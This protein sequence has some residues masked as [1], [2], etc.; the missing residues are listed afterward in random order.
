[1]NSVGYSVCLCKLLMLKQSIN[2]ILLSNNHSCI[3][4]LHN[5][6]ESIDLGEECD[7]N[8]YQVQQA[9]IDA[10]FMSFL[11]QEIR[12]RYIVGQE[13]VFLIFSFGG[14]TVPENQEVITKTYQLSLSTVIFNIINSYRGL[15][16]LEQMRPIKG[17]LKTIYKNEDIIIVMKPHSLLVHPWGHSLA[18]TLM[19]WLVHEYPELSLLPRAGIVHRL[20]RDTTGLLIIARNLA[21]QIDLIWKISNHRFI[22]EYMAICEGVILNDRGTISCK[23]DTPRYKPK[24]QLV[25][26]THF[27]V[28][29]RF[30]CCTYLRLNLETG[31]RHQI[32][33]HLSR[34]LN[35]PLI[36]DRLYNTRFVQRR[37][38]LSN[39]KEYLNQFHRP[40]LHASRI[41]IELLRS[42][43]LLIIKVNMPEDMDYLLDE[44]ASEEQ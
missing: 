10:C 22:R 18:P 42:N 1:M 30:D 36:G 3:T 35:C 9:S 5:L 19:N 34:H 14:S 40:A 26:I 6:L 12:N 17:D 41:V 4:A 16:T 24:D 44:I 13:R 20:D 38:K 27:S 15:F 31:R 25:G 8:I 32:R 33:T 21:S 23:V 28:I 39:E 11:N 37:I 29:R 7:L 2:G 43:M